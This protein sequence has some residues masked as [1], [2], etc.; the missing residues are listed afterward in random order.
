MNSKT[1]I[2]KLFRYIVPILFLF[3]SVGGKGQDFV[4]PKLDTI[5]VDRWCVTL[6]EFDENGV[7]RSKFLECYKIVTHSDF[8]DE[9]GRLILSGNDYS[10]I[11]TY[12]YLDSLV[13][14][15]Q[16]EVVDVESMKDVFLLKDIKKT[17]YENGKKIREL[18]YGVDRYYPSDCIRLFEPKLY[19]DTKY[20]VDGNVVWQEGNWKIRSYLLGDGTRREVGYG[21][22]TSNISVERFYYKNGD[23]REVDYYDDE[24]CFYY[25]NGDVKRYKKGRLC[26][27]SITEKKSKKKTMEDHGEYGVYETEDYFDD[28]GNVTKRLHFHNGKIVSKHIYEYDDDSK[29]IFEQ[30]LY[31]YANNPNKW[32]VKE[33]KKYTYNKYGG[34]DCEYTREYNK[35]T[36]CYN[37]KTIC[38]KDY[39]RSNCCDSA[40]NRQLYDINFFKS[41]LLNDVKVVCKMIDTTLKPQWQDSVIKN[42]TLFLYGYDAENRHIKTIVCTY[43]SLLYNPWVKSYCVDFLYDEKQRVSEI[44]LYR[45]A[46]DEK[47]IFTV[48]IVYAYRHRKAQ[49]QKFLW[50]KGRII[51]QNDFNEYDNW[52]FD[53]AI[54]KI[55]TCLKSENILLE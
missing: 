27:S 23:R 8:Y 13:I 6:G 11:Y 39:K 34:I 3:C 32:M 45:Y 46:F 18:S 5:M 30:F 36:K 7:M 41:L 22:D 47:T 52:I 12:E 16:Y 17:Y 40:Y 1:F 42:D 19:K 25:K 55:K 9:Q 29:C 35:Y 33:E 4:M 28:R 49:M 14:T 48:K 24:E 20:D 54:A 51:E 43:D 15:K 53:K 38:N 44:R 2:L 31:P 26:Y 10:D 37:E 50:G 21:Y